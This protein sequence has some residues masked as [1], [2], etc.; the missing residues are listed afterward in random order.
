M[1]AEVRSPRLPLKFPGLHLID[2]TPDPGLSG[3]IGADERVL[4]F[5]EMLSGMLILGRVATPHMATAQA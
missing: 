3:L 5:L 2:I 4:R 1:R